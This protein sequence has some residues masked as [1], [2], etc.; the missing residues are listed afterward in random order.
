MFRC[1]TD[2]KVLAFDGDS[3][4]TSDLDIISR[5][6]NDYRIIIMVSGNNCL[7]IK[8]IFNSEQIYIMD[9][10]Q[11]FLAPNKHTHTDILK[12]LEIKATELVYVSRRIRFLSNAMSFIGGTAWITDSV[13]YEDASRAPDIIC[14]K[15]TKLRDYLNRRIYG[16]FGEVTI[17][18]SEDING[19][20]IIPVNFNLDDGFTPLYTLGRYYGYSQYMSQLHPYSTAIYYNKKVGSKCYGIFN[21]PFSKIM[22]RAIKRVLEQYNVDGVCSVPPRPGE[23]NRFHDTLESISSECG[24][25]N[26]ESLFICIDAYPPQKGLPS[27]ERENNIRGVFSFKERLNGENI[28]II[29][30]VISTGSTIRECINVLKAAGAGNI[31]IVVLGIN[32]MGGNYWS[33]N[34]IQVKCPRCEA[35]MFLASNSTTRKFFYTCFNCRLETMSF[36]QGRHIIESIA[37][38][39]FNGNDK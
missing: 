1:I 29:D 17:Y 38:S 12:R 30:D 11:Q 14:Q 10:F 33:S 35:K 4:N 6:F 9:E 18:P 37:N 26:Y 39:E 22:I 32:Q 19:G 34:T 16:F 3:F 20:L 13:S 25:I 24:I 2:V 15:L 36:N 5:E 28:I 8:K 21:D 27:Y 31:Y 23:I 7:P